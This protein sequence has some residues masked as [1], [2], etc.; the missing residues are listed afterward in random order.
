MKNGISG[1]I[2]GFTLIELLVVVL[3]ISILAA[4]AL[5][6]YKLAVAKSRIG[7]LLTIAK[8]VLQAEESYYLAN[9]Q[10]TQNWDELAV[11]VAGKKEPSYPEVMNFSH[12]SCGLGT[13]GVS[14]SG[15]AGITIYF[16]YSH[17]VHSFRG[18]TSCYA[19]MKDD[20]ANKV[21]QA[22]THKKNPNS[23]NGPDTQNIYHF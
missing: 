15:G 2:G 23:N 5:P 3:I 19:N 11:E 20:F 4:V 6:Q 22:L 1:K 7:S 14:V 8:E 9:G 13:M 16:F 10:Y 17:V 18:K 12:G 21:C